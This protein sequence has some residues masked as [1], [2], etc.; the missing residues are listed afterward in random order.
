V[1]RLVTQPENVDEEKEKEKSW[2]HSQSP[3]RSDDSLYGDS[4]QRLSGWL[5][6]W[7]PR[8][9]IA[10][11]AYRMARVE[12][13][14]SVQRK[15]KAWICVALTIFASFFL[16]PRPSRWFQ[17]YT[18]FRHARCASIAHS[19]C[20]SSRAPKM[21]TDGIELRV[22]RMPACSIGLIRSESAM[23]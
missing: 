13:G 20:S 5:G 4:H 19:S 1:T 22:Q 9:G 18:S 17:S 7:K 14:L 3:E 2:E 8:A 12:P 21:S 11:G 15:T 6:P 10:L 23:F 16:L